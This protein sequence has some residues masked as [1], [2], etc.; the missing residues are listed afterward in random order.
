[1]VKYPFRRGNSQQLQPPTWDAR[2]GCGIATI[3]VAPVMKIG[4]FCIPQF[5]ELSDLFVGEVEFMV[6]NITC[7][8]VWKNRFPAAFFNNHP[9][10]AVISSPSWPWEDRLTGEPIGLYC[11][12]ARNGGDIYYVYPWYGSQY[13]IGYPKNWMVN[14]KN[15]LKFPYWNV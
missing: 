8:C 7:W 13:K 14:T 11:F 1:M 12:L 10:R 9:G 5:L 4:L 2:S 15:T 6:F 3:I